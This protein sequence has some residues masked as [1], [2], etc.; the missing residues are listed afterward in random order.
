MSEGEVGLAVSVPV[1]GDD[2]RAVLTGDGDGGSEAAQAGPREDDGVGLPVERRA[3]VCHDDVGEAVAV[4]V[5]LGGRRR[6]GA[7]PIR[8]VGGRRVSGHAAKGSVPSA[9]MVNAGVP[10]RVAMTVTGHKTRSVFDRYHI[11][12]PG[13]LQDVARRLTG[14]MA[15]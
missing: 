4:V 14:T 5:Q 2:P 1:V 8:D 12:S 13:D 15:L 10:E 3:A 11:V 9:D 7:D 6:E